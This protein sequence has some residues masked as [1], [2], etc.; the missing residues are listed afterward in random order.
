MNDNENCLAYF[1]VQFTEFHILRRKASIALG[2]KSQSVKHFHILNVKCLCMLFRLCRNV[3]S[4]QI[5]AI[6][7]GEHE[8]WTVKLTHSIKIDVNIGL[9]RARIIFCFEC[10]P[11]TSTIIFSPFYLTLFSVS[12]LF[13]R[14][15]ACAL[16]HTY[17]H[18]QL[19]TYTDSHLQMYIVLLL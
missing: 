4:T 8:E 10:M 17:A 14:S 19:H 5:S 1:R 9:I 12:R 7:R 13:V 2:P 6:S 18:A 3:R 16:A 11:C 15:F